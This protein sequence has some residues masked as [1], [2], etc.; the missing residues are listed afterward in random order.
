MSNDPIKTPP[1]TLPSF[2]NRK[3]DDLGS[4]PTGADLNAIR[5]FLDIVQEERVLS[6]GEVQDWKRSEK[7]VLE[8]Q[9]TYKEKMKTN[10]A[11]GKCSIYFCM[12]FTLPVFLCV[13]L[14]ESLGETTPYFFTRMLVRWPINFIAIA[15]FFFY[16]N[17]L[18]QAP[19]HVQSKKSEDDGWQDSMTSTELQSRQR[20][21]VDKWEL[22]KKQNKIELGLDRNINLACFFNMFYFVCRLIAVV[23]L[24]EKNAY[25]LYFSSFKEDTLNAMLNIELLFTI[26]FIFLFYQQFPETEKTEKKSDRKL[27]LV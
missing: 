15:I 6:Y 4:Q 19:K 25:I 14:T 2:I 16:M 9:N 11:Q 12:F 8:N 7:K 13:Y 5:V 1:G 3:L 21:L 10:E 17:S 27:H 24:M 23:V 20:A 22:V 26:V 18:S